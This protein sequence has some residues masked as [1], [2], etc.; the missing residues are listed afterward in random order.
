MPKLNTYELKS[1]VDG[2]LQVL[3]IIPG[4]GAEFETVRVSQVALC[5]FTS[6]EKAK[7]AGL[8]SSHFKGMYVSLAALEI[9]HPTGSAGD[10]ADV[11]SGAGS[12]VRRY[13]WDVSDS[14]WQQ[15]LL[16]EQGPPGEGAAA[17]QQKDW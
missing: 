8:E 3:G 17:W 12:A 5:N 11:D 9:A 10:Y 2:N 14:Q 16:V 6:A 4:N 13:I 15:V 1:S 7:L